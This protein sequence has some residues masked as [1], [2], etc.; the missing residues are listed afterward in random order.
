[1]SSWS[2]APFQAHL[3]GLTKALKRQAFWKTALFGT[4]LL[5]RQWP[6]YQR[7]SVGRTWGAPKELRSVLDRF[8]QAIPTGV[9]IND[10][11]LL[12]LEEHPVEPQT[13]PWDPVA[14][15]L[16]QSALAL[17]QVF[18]SKDKAAAGGCAERNLQALSLFLEAV[19][20]PLTPDHPLAAAELSFQT[21]L[22]QRLCAVPNGDKP[23][24]VSAARQEAFGSLLGERWFP[25]YPD[26]P[27]LKGRRKK[28][29]V[30]RYTSGKFDALL[31]QLLAP[32]REGRDERWRWRRKIEEDDQR[33]QAGQTQT[34][35]PLPPD[36][37]ARAYDRVAWDA[38]ILAKLSWALTRDAGETRSCFHLAAQATES[39]YALLDRG[40]PGGDRLI[41]GFHQSRDLLTPAVCAYLSN[42]RA[43]ALKLLHRRWDTVPGGFRVLPIGQEAPPQNAWCDQPG[44]EFL[45]ALLRDGPEAA[46]PLLAACGEEWCARF[47]LLQAKDVQGLRR[48]AE[49]QVR[50]L[51][52]S[53]D[54]EAYRP[55][56][57][58]F[59][60]FW[61]KLARELGLE[62]QPP[63]VVELPEPLLDDTPADPALCPLPGQVFLEAALGP[64]GDRVLARWKGRFNAQQEKHP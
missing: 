64:E 54:Y 50:K 35:G 28:E 40:W 3:E 13:E 61:Y 63:H 46:L 37:P 4:I 2:A 18:W 17:L 21:A 52:Q 25:S 14:G 29:P 19:E 53:Y 16:L 33:L 6:V 36:Y 24:F 56:L 42:D 43:L 8:W 47:G 48:Y 10:K 12:L 60:L 62:A 49:T 51:R 9:R 20:E 34:V 27:P 57:A 59:P 15:V 39:C 26:Y 55:F 45:Y 31:P 23:V 5:E 32:D 41:A 11:Y 1:M 30:L 7:L 44:L 22:C 58:F 38:L